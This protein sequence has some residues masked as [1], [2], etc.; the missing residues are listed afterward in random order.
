LKSIFLLWIWTAL[1]LVQM[2]R[3]KWSLSVLRDTFM[4]FVGG[5]NDRQMVFYSKVKELLCGDVVVEML[6]DQSFSRL[7][8][9]HAPCYWGVWVLDWVM[10][11]L[12]S[13]RPS[14]WFLLFAWTWVL[15]SCTIL[16]PKKKTT[17]WV[18]CFIDAWQAFIIMLDQ[19][20]FLTD[21]SWCF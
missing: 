16:S 12:Q 21:L 1:L 9:W 20:S 3:H 6:L 11:P 19:S 18:L 10:F 14:W 15:P 4:T 7:L 13:A 5:D 17:T 2:K 8:I